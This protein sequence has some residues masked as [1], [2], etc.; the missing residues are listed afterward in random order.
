MQLLFTARESPE[1]LN[2]TAASSTITHDIPPGPLCPGTFVT[3]ISVGK[4]VP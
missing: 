2:W 1:Q 4:E 3:A